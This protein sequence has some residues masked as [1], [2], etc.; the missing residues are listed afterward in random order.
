[1][2]EKSREKWIGVPVPDAGLER[3]VVEAAREAIRDNRKTSNAGHR[4]WELSGG[5]HDAPST[6]DAW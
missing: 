2:T 1:V 5:F 3:E 4:Y 6:S